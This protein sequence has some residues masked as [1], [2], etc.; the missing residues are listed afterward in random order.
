MKKM[1][2]SAKGQDRRI[3]RFSRFGRMLKPENQ[4]ECAGRKEGGAKRVKGIDK[5][6]CFFVIIQVE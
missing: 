3:G 6:L 4:R 5:G 2:V 1:E